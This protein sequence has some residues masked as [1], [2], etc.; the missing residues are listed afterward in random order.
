MLLR[1]DGGLIINLPVYYSCGTMTYHVN[2]SSKFTFSPKNT[3]YAQFTRK[4][5]LKSHP[6]HIVKDLSLKIISRRDT[7][8]KGKLFL[9][10]TTLENSESIFEKRS[11]MK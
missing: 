3:G 6:G 7:A 8:V 4:F 10:K 1:A 11:Y 5:T 9:I 2:F